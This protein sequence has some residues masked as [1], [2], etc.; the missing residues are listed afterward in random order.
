MRLK[1]RPV[2]ISTLLPE[3]A[4][5]T[6]LARTANSLADLAGAVL[7]HPGDVCASIEALRP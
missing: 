7:G 6:A 3:E 2:E 1:A 4:A 5:H